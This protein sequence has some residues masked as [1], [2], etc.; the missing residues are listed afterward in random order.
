MVSRVK[1]EI[2]G[3]D[4]LLQGGLPKGSI[5]MV[6]GGPGTGKSILCQQIVYNNAMNGLKCLYASFEQ[7]EK[8]IVTQM[9]QFGFDPNKTKGKLKILS[10]NL[11]NPGVVD[12]F[13]EEFNKGHFNLVVIDSVAS[14]YINPIPSTNKQMKMVEI[15]E[16]VSPVPVEE[17][18]LKK[19]EIREI[20]NPMQENDTTVLM[21]NQTTKDSEY[22]RDEVSEYLCDGIMVLHTVEGEEGFRTVTIPKMRLTKQ[23]SGIYSFQIGKKGIEVKIEN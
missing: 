6:T 9:K 22:S 4:N 3:L 5:T 12:Y 19:L 10:L 1:T 8:N 23:K 17:S 15:S 20:I 13:L 16:G 21:I 11:S 14:L 2:K 18:S 7:P